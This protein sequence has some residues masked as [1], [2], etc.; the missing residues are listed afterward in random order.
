M[1][2]AS[3]PG[4]RLIVNPINL[5]YLRVLQ[6]RRAYRQRRVPA[7]LNNDTQVL[8]DWLDPLL[9]PFRRSDVS[10]VGSSR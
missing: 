10:A 4:I 5:G 7:A 6:H 8:A 3:V 2:L 9:L 1:H